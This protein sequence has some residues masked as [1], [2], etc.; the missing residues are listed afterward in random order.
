[1]TTH[2]SILVWKIPRT[3]EPG[4]TLSTGSKS[5]TQLCTAQQPSLNYNIFT[6]LATL[7]FIYYMFPHIHHFWA[8]QEQSMQGWLTRKVSQPG[9]YLKKG[10]C[11][12]LPWWSS[13]YAPTIGG[14]GSIPG[15]GTKI[16]HAMQSGQIIFFKVLLLCWSHRT[17]TFD[18]CKHNST[19]AGM[20]YREKEKSSN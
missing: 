8:S 17:S 10:Y 13:G 14:L 19:C 4:V 12:G 20:F 5:Q 6:A 11:W 2:Y 15:Q 1:M 7:C 16:P 3:E 9:W 18:T